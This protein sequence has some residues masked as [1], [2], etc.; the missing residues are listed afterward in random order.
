MT[1]TTLYG[2]FRARADAAGSYQRMHEAGLRRGGI[3]S[4]YR[5]VA[6]QRAIFLARYTV[7]FAGSGPFGDV[8]WYQ[9]RRYVRTSAAGQV[10]VP[11]TSQHN[12]GLAIDVS[13]KSK[14]HSW[15]VAHGPDF[16]WRRTIPAEPWHFEYRPATDQAFHSALERAVHL[17]ADGHWGPKADAGVKA[18]RAASRLKGVKFPY[19]VDYTEARVGRPADGDWDAADR[20]AHDASVL[21]LRLAFGLTAGTVWDTEAD[22]A[23][24]A[25]RKVCLR[26]K[27]A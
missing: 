14:V 18:V 16:G 24:L 13:T 7:Q 26:K 21:S 3:N 2:D 11:G 12:F 27:R 9:G 5:S 25:A 1:L 17:K 20:S 15:M 10:G 4:A 23:F 22:A 8:R 6:T 19:G